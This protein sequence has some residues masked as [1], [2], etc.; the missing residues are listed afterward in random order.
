VK[1]QHIL[2]EIR[3]TAR[4][5]AG[6]PLGRERFTSETGIRES[7]WLGKHW[8]RW[9]D[10]VREAGFEPNKLQ[11]ATDREGLVEKFVGLIRELGHFPVATELRMH[12]RNN[13]GFPWHNTFERLGSKAKRARV[14]IDYCR[15]RGGFDDVITLCEPIAAKATLTPERE[16]DDPETGYVYLM[17]SGKHYKIGRTNAL[18]R[19]EYELAIQLPERASTVHTI[20]TDDPPGI[21]AYW[22]QRFADR[23]KN[24]EWFELTMADVKAFKR[25]KYM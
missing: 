3:R 13:P 11:D 2:D 8:A 24:G 14:V 5:N 7:D 12:A 15:E 19:R 4:E 9:G 16:P 10:A 20:K 1:K 17:K 22:H 6:K 21:E 18:G 23:R 25:R